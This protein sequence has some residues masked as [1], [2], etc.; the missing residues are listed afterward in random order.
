MFLPYDKLQ[1]FVTPEEVDLCFQEADISDPNLVEFVLKS[2]KRLFLLLIL[3]SDGKEQKLSLLEDFAHENINDAVLPIEIKDGEDGEQYGFSLPDGP[4][5][6]IFRDWSDRDVRDFETLQYM[7]NVP[8]FDSSRFQFH[9]QG[10]EILPYLG[11]VT[12]AAEVS[13][14]FFG[15]VSKIEI[16]PAHIPA[17]KAVSVLSLCISPTPS[18]RVN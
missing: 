13:E 7:L 6:S 15:E 17:I 8:V 9:F 5:F 14:G 4:R 2:A 18:P 12:K 11:I 3:M 10:K 1:G 16:H